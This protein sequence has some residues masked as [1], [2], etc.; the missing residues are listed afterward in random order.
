MDSERA[1]AKPAREELLETARSEGPDGH[2]EETDPEYRLE[3]DPTAPAIEDARP[4]PTPGSPDRA[5]S[6]EPVPLP[7][8][9][10]PLGETA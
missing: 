6:C 9:V 7:L 10:A 4:P 1:P 8:P 5:Q 2:R 3:D